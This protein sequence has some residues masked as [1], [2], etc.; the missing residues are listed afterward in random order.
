MALE[1]IGQKNARDAL[2]QGL[3]D[4]SAMVRIHSIRATAV[5]LK[6]DSEMYCD[7]MARWR[8]AGAGRHR[9]TGPGITNRVKG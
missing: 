7:Q 4:R 9:A 6:K 3:L 5:S 1:S 2:M 8:T